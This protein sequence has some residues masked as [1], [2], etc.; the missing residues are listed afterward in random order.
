MQ[1]LLDQLSALAGEAFAA[2]GLDP[3]FG[4]VQ[5]SDRPDLAPFQCNGALIAA[6]KA[7]KN[8]REMAEVIAEH[9]RGLTGQIG[10]ETIA[11]PGFLHINLDDNFIVEQ[12]VGQI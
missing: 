11:G 9:L 8:P 5:V 10:E 3:S 4:Q 2:E 6:K 1:S 12:A 7:K